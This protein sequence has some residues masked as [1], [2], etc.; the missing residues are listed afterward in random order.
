MIASVDDGVQAFH[1]VLS[2]GGVFQSEL[3]VL[4]DALL[5]L[6]HETIEANDRLVVLGSGEPP[7]ARKDP[8]RVI[9]GALV[10][11][12]GVTLFAC[13]RAS[14]RERCPLPVNMGDVS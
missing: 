10:R 14:L 13:V 12:C 2:P 9:N 5:Q 1:F 6:V 8:A 4:V 7:S 3:D 11:Q